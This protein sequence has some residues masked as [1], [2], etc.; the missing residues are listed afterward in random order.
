ML[1]I[2]LRKAR[3]PA[4]YASGATRETEELAREAVEAGIRRYCTAR[5]E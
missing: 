3:Q 1:S 4:E 2:P 5:R